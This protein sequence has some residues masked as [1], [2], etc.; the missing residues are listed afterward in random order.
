MNILD[1]VGFVAGVVVSILVF[2]ICFFRKKNGFILVIISIFSVILFV[3]A[4][5]FE[6]RPIGWFATLVFLMGIG[7]IRAEGTTRFRKSWEWSKPK[8]YTKDK[9]RRYIGLI[10]VWS[11]FVILLFLD[12][13]FEIGLLER[14]SNTF[15]R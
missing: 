14:L 9:R 12:L 11:I 4:I 10:F 7:L 13:F 3:I 6:V 2:I 1:F 5:R 8:E 15:G